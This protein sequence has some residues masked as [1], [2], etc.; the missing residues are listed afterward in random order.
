M[1]TFQSSELFGA[2]LVFVAVFILLVLLDLCYQYWN[3]SDVEK[4]ISERSHTLR[5]RVKKVIA[6]ILLKLGRRKAMNADKVDQ[7]Q[8]FSDDDPMVR[9]AWTRWRKG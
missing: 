5:F 4:P 3:S 9:A 2:F 7:I 6:R 8:V 1:N